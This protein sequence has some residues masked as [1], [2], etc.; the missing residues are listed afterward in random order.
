MSHFLCKRRQ[1]MG[2]KL[3][4]TNFYYS[5]NVVDSFT[6]AVHRSNESTT[7]NMKVKQFWPLKNHVKIWIGDQNKRWQ[8]L[9]DI[10]SRESIKNLY[11][12]ICK[13]YQLNSFSKLYFMNFMNLFPSNVFQEFVPQTKFLINFIKIALVSLMIKLL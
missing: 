3:I 13:F 8:K 11:I 7:R 9:N 4:N 10:F 1:K 5:R 2:A 6:V 12:R